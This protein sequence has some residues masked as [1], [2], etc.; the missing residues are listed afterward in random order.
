MEHLSLPQ[1]ATR[2][3]VSRQRVWVWVRNGQLRATLICGR[4]AVD[5]EDCHHPADLR[6]VNS[7]G[8]KTISG[9]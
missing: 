4:W 6:R 2:L 1:V 8:L 5:T 9:A 7:R 3:G